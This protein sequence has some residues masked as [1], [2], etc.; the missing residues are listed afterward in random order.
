M[1]AA[2][3]TWVLPLQL[4]HEL[5]LPSPGQS[6]VSVLWLYTRTADNKNTRRSPHTVSDHPLTSPGCGGHSQGR[7]GHFCRGTAKIL[8]VVHNRKLRPREGY[9]QVGSR[10]NPHLPGLELQESLS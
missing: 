3:S 4:G 9:G 6:P 10:E 1:K 5:G 7:D 8:L 2:A